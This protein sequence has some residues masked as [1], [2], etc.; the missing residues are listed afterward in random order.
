MHKPEGEWVFIFW[1]FYLSDCLQSTFGNLIVN[2]VQLEQLWL[3][4]GGE[5]FRDGLHGRLDE[6]SELNTEHFDLVEFQAWHCLHNGQHPII[7]EHCVDDVNEWKQVAQNGARIVQ[8]LSQVICIHV[9]VS[10][11]CVPCICVINFNV[12]VGSQHALNASEEVEHSVV[13]MAENFGGFLHSPKTTRFGKICR[14]WSFLAL[15]F[16]DSPD[17]EIGRNRTLFRLP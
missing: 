11:A 5:P 13:E 15:P 14:T 17:V 10:I 1:K 4:A 8:L 7:R 9:T 16:V 6:A 3:I 12:C 2:A